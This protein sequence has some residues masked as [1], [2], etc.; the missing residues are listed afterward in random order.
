MN[1]AFRVDASKKIGFG[2]WF[3]CNF[4]A[5]IINNEKIFF[6][7]KF[8]PNNF[9]NKNKFKIISLNK[10]NITAAQEIKEI[11]NKLKK[12][13]I[14]ILIIDNYST[15]LYFEKSIK[16]SVKKLIIIDDFINKKHFGDIYINNNFHEKRRRIQIKKNNP[17]SKLALGPKYLLLNNKYSA[18]KKKIKQKL[19]IKKVLIFFGGSDLTSETLKTVKAI[20]NLDNVKFYL[21]IGSMN[22]DKKKILNIVKKNKNFKTFEK[23]PNYKFGLIM[24]KCDLAIGAGGINLFERLYLALPSIVISTSNNQITNALYSKKRGFIKY[25]GYH[26]NVSEKDI[27]KSVNY[28]INNLKFFRKFSKKCYGALKVTSFKKLIKLINDKI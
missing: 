18:I 26:Q 20:K 8:Y 22:K 23:L 17:I 5:N 12:N 25:L 3:R 15:N 7:S 21:I 4:F 11:K 2:H 14:D 28:L 27:K 1:I 9:K 16:N 13:K 19:E 10:K 6:F 24:A